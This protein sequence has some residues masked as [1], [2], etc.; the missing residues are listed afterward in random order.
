MIYYLDEPPGD[1]APLNACSSVSWHASMAAKSCYQGLA[2]DILYG[3]PPPLCFAAGKVLVLDATDGPAGVA[4]CNA[5]NTYV[6]TMGSP[7]DQAFQYADYTGDERLVS[8]FYWLIRMSS[9]V[10]TPL[11]YA[12]IFAI[13]HQPHHACCV[14]LSA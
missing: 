12:R 13:S 5:P 6:C 7:L 9:K 3:L 1:P 14:N 10:C 11:S 2:G 4:L 8:Y